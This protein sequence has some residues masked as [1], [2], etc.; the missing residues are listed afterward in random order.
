MMKDILQFSQML[1]DNG[2][3]ASVR[4]T[5]N[6]CEAIPLIESNSADLKEVLAS[7]YLKDYRQRNKFDKLYDQCFQGTGEL[8]KPLEDSISSENKGKFI[9]SM[10]LDSPQK[11]FHS[12]TKYVYTN[13]QFNSLKDTLSDDL[14]IEYLENTLGGKNNSNNINMDSNLLQSNLTSLNALQPEL[15]ELCQQ[16]GRKLASKRAR[17]NKLAKKQTPDIRKSI[18]KNLK[19]GGTLL[20]LVKSKPKIKKQ[21]HYFLSDVSIS[22]DWISLWFF[23]MIYVAQ[24]TFHKTRA[25]E[26]DNKT[27]EIT[28]ALDELNLINAFLNVLE[29][30]QKNS[31]IQGK[32]NMYTSFESF[33]E[34]ANLNS[35]SYVMILSDCRDWAGPKIDGKQASAEIIREI[36]KKA[37]KVLILNPEPKLKWDVAD[38][39]ISLYG[40]AGAEIHEVRNLEQLANLIS[41]I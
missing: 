15:I 9:K 16:L 13:Y 6:A 38:S 27:A 1:R 17:R 31:M 18:R 40:D 30:R 11:S 41:S 19:N 14:K 24:N 29:I 10:K 3:P 33:L 20:E 23:C 21:N 5:K 32:S 34:Q 39:C 2:I 28:S 26:F 35:K 7:I 8:E 12:E 22:C 4:S 36:S 37:K 25:F